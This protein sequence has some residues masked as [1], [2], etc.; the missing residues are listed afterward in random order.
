MQLQWCTGLVS[1]LHAEDGISLGVTG[2]PLLAWLS[3]H[4]RSN[5][6]DKSC[7]NAGFTLEQVIDKKAAVKFGHC[8]DLAAFLLAAPN[9]P[10]Q[11]TA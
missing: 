4:F 10:Q 3:L 2:I 9:V 11:R 8:K 5:A 6:G 7:D 1:S